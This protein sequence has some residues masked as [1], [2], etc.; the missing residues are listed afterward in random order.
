MDGRRTY[1]Y[2][3][4]RTSMWQRLPRCRPHAIGNHDNSKACTINSIR[5]YTLLFFLAAL[6]LLG[7][8]TRSSTS[9][10][11]DCSLLLLLLILLLLLSTAVPG[12]ISTISL[13]LRTRYISKTEP[14]WQYCRF[15]SLGSFY[16]TCIYH[17]MR[18]YAE[19]RRACARR[20]GAPPCK[21]HNT[22]RRML[23][24]ACVCMQTF[25]GPIF[26]LFYAN[27]LVLFF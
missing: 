20:V 24:Q 12:I 1:S 4:T 6:Y 7:A 18:A 25:P 10:P 23:M 2:I 15:C 16:H 19:P 3:T 27:F 9:P 5:V 17:S 14:P 21:T 11:P 8:D 22:H 13:K 26:P